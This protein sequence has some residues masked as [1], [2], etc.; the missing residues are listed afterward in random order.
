MPELGKVYVTHPSASSLL[1]YGASWRRPLE[2]VELAMP[3]MAGVRSVATYVSVRAQLRDSVDDGLRALSE[4]VAT[5]PEPRDTYVE[6][7]T[8]LEK[9]VARLWALGERAGGPRFQLNVLDYAGIRVS[10]FTD[11]QK[12]QLL[13]LIGLYVGNLVR[14]KGIALDS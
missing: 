9:L 7:R 1:V 14:P 11:A 6:P 13:D 2:S 5:A 10:S 8:P 4:R 3:E 12:K